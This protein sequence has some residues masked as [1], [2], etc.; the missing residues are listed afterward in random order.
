MS[1]KQDRISARTVSDLERKYKFGESFAEAMGLAEDAKE[2]AESAKNAADE[3]NQAFKDLDQESIFNLLTNN[4]K[5]KGIYR[6]DNGEIYVNAS[7]I[8]TGSLLA[9]LIKTGVIKSADGSVELDLA[10]N[11]VTIATSD[12]NNEGKIVLSSTGAVFYGMDETTGVLQKF[13]RLWPGYITSDGQNIASMITTPYL[14]A[15][16]HIQANKN[17]FLGNTNADLT[18][19]GKSIT[20]E[21]DIN[22]SSFRVFGLGEPE[23]DT[24]AANKAY[25]DTKVS[26]AL[27]WENDNPTSSFDP[28]AMIVNNMGDFDMVRVVFELVAGGS[29]WDLYSF[30]NYSGITDKCAA[31]A[32]FYDGGVYVA[33]RAYSIDWANNIINFEDAKQ[34]GSTRNDRMIPVKI[35]GIKGIMQ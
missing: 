5:S 35:Y 10:N 13:L 19:Y 23:D 28:K 30:E 34:N 7:Y 2:T 27:L 17:L 32:T 20:F 33:S 6:D 1:S 3:A 24:D 11:T 31:T 15:S 12:G 4:G 21:K 14:Q 25:V 18:V 9:D 22:M 26:M 8:Q 16:L 29:A